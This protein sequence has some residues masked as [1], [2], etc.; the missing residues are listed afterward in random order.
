MR[1]YSSMR[2]HVDVVYI[3]PH[4]WSLGTGLA[5]M[6]TGAY[7]NELACATAAN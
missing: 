3:H 2:V 5:R 7:Y 4:V 6:R 1:V